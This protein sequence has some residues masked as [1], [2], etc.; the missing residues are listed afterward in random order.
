MGSP[1][2]EHY[3][4]PETEEKQ[5]QFQDALA[6]AREQREQKS[7]DLENARSLRQERMQDIRD[8]KELRMMDQQEALES[9]QEKISS[10]L[11]NP[12]DMGFQERYE[13]IMGDPDIHKARATTGGRQAI[14]SMLQEAKASHA[15]YLDSWNKIGAGYGWSGDPRTLPRNKDGSVNWDLSVEKVFKPAQQQRDQLQAQQAMQKKI[16]ERE[17][18]F[19]SGL[20]AGELSP[21]GEMKYKYEKGARPKAIPLNSLPIEEQLTVLRGLKRNIDPNLPHEQQKKLLM[22]LAKKSGY[23]Y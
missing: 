1:Y 2:L 3:L 12:A 9:A 19:K 5:A 16:Q 8:R 17:T 15:D 6:L 11:G 4:S 22:D 18:A 13:K 23:T 7:F 20:V 14:D 21:E 10:T